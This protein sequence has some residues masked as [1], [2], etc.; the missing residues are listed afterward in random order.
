M[1]HLKLTRVKKLT[2]YQKLAIGTWKDAKDPSIYSSL[3]IDYS[4]AKELCD[5]IFQENQIK[6]TP[7]YIVAQAA[8]LIFVVRPQLNV[9]LRGGLIYRRDIVS[10]SFLVAMDAVENKKKIFNLS[11]CVVHDMSQYGLIDLYKKLKDKITLTK[12]NESNN[13]RVQNTLLGRIPS[14]LMKYFLNMSSFVMYFLNIRLKGVPYDPFGALMISN[15]GQIGIDNAFIPLVPY[16]KSPMFLAI[17][18]VQARPVAT[19]DRQV[20]VR[21]ILKLNATIDHRYIDGKSLA[22]MKK[23][24]DVILEDPARWLIPA[25]K[26]IQEEFKTEFYTKK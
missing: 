17:G 9:M 20:V 6:I 26:D 22:I 21:D 13:A 25:P 15:L 4:K 3:D 10:F 5:K 1:K 7:T 11:N 24:L 23:M 14:P 19:K 16:A 12:N 8:A 18:L 2:T